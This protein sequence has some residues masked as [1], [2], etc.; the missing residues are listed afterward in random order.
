MNCCSHLRTVAETRD[1]EEVK[2]CQEGTARVLTDW[3]GGLK[4]PVSRGGRSKQ[5]NTKP[6]VSEFEIPDYK[7]MERIQLDEHGAFA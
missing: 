4:L 7:M 2:F 5:N 1:I 6:C 3:H